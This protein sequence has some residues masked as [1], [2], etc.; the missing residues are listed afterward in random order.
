MNRG[1]KYLSAFILW[2]DY[3][4]AIKASQNMFTECFHYSALF[5][6]LVCFENFRINLKTTKNWKLNCK[7]ISSWF[8]FDQQKLDW[9]SLREVECES[10][11]RKEKYCG[12]SLESIENFKNWLLKNLPNFSTMRIST[13]LAVILTF[14]ILER[15]HCTTGN[16]C[17]CYPWHFRW[18]SKICINSN[19]NVCKTWL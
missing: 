6:I 12:I 13:V 4:F 10:R 8:N 15:F 3:I 1:K 5:I 14:L 18:V 2:V 11:R 16:F 9:L 7:T 17:F 19:W